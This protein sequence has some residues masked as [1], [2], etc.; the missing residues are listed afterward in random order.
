MLGLSNAGKTTILYQLKLNQAI[1]TIHTYSF[2]KETIQLQSGSQFTIWDYSGSRGNMRFWYRLL[3][4]REPVI[5]VVDSTERSCFEEARDELN[6][7]MT[8]DYQ[9]FFGIVL[10]LCTK[11]D[12]PG[13]ASVKEIRD[14][15]ELDRVWKFGRR[16]HICGVSGLTGEG[17]WEGLEWL[18]TQLQGPALPSPYFPPSTSIVFERMKIKGK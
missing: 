17:I 10:V 4:E 5:F 6:Y 13:A 8:E 3:Q 12:L 1:T 7:A 14:V 11:Q 18:E 16:W 9:T 15:L 2:N